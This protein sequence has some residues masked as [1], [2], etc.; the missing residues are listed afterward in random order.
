MV[1][2]KAKPSESKRSGASIKLE[3]KSGSDF[4]IIQKHIETTMPG[5]T[6]TKTD[7][8]GHALHLAAGAI[9]A[10]TPASG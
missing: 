5:V 3:G 2:Q 9:M 10:K 1:D 4:L 7:V 8:L 6:T